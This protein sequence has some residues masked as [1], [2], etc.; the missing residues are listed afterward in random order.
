MMPFA[1]PTALENP[2]RI[3]SVLGQILVAHY[4][5][6][7]ITA[8][9]DYLHARQAS[10]WSSEVLLG[11]VGHFCQWSVVRCQWSWTTIFRRQA[12]RSTCVSRAIPAPSRRRFGRSI[13]HKNSG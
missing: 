10:Q 1:N 11:G 8:D 5:L 4:D 2:L 13:R 3:A 6:R 9:T 7:H 12:Y